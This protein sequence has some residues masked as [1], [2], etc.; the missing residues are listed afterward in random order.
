LLT[1]AE[2]Y[3]REC[4]LDSS[5]DADE[6]SA[7]VWQLVQL[8]TAL[9]VSRRSDGDHGVYLSL[10]C[11]CDWKREHGWQLVFFSRRNRGC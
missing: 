11:S 2:P 1:E 10:T 8:G 7:D 5:E 9:I 3:V 6:P 4:Y